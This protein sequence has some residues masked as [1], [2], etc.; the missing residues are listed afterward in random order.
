MSAIIKSKV[1]TESAVGSSWLPAA[2][3]LYDE[4]NLHFGS[5]HS[6]RLCYNKQNNMFMKWE[7]NRGC[8]L[9][10]ID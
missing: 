7:R 2:D 5:L 1:R 9:R 8:W 6:G 10:N 4:R 3:F